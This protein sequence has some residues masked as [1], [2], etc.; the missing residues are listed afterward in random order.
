MTFINLINNTADAFEK[1]IREH[2]SNLAEIPTEEFGWENTRWQSDN[3]RLAHIERFNQPNFSVLHTLIF[4]H[5][6]DPS[7]I[8]GFD[9]IAS[10]TKATGLFFDLSP[11]LEDWGPLS[12][13]EYTHT[14]EKPEWG[15]IFSDNW[16]ACRPSFEEAEEICGL[17]CKIL[18]DYI[19]KIN[20]NRGC[21][22]RIIGAQNNYSFKQR[23]NPHTTKVLIKL[24]GEER[25]NY[26]INK[27]LFP[28]I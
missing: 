20:I 1:I 6:L 27:V 4:P 7:P 16:I 23:Q 2:A 28:V 25:G 12:S 17:A 8:F 14:R 21:E 22:S 18:Q 11:S 3:F 10:E 24:L 13:K 15:D 26:F 5:T 9:I 19:L